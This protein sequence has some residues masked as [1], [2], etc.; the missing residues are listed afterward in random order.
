MT[1]STAFP[2]SPTAYYVLHGETVTL[3]CSYSIEFYDMAWLAGDQRIYHASR[4]TS[5][6]VTGD[7]SERIQNHEF[8]G[9]SHKITVV[10]N[11][12]K[13]ENKTFTCRVATFTGI[14][15]DSEILPSILSKFSS[16]RL[17]KLKS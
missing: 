4:Q 1:Y 16:S 14:S 12:T 15:D 6:I 5:E 11:K 3:K 8:E 2:K 10:V 17:I 13:D 7:V 9:N